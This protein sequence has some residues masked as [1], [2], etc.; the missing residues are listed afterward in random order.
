MLI[1]PS[2]D[3]PAVLRRSLEAFRACD[4]VTL[5]EAFTHDASLVTQVDSKLARRLGLT[6]LKGGGP[7]Q[8]Q[9]AIQI[10]QFYALEFATFDVTHFEVRDTLIVGRDVAATCE[11]GMKIRDGGPSFYGRCHN[12]WT[13]DA[14]GRKII[15]AR[16]LCK[17]ISPDGEFKIN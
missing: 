6:D 7:L 10:M 8:A 13:M 1:R 5:A 14:S 4:P 3:V 17:I 11:W 9:G 12:I 16:N 15:D 2:L